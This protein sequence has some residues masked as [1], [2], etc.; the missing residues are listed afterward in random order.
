MENPHKPT[1][2]IHVTKYIIEQSLRM[3]CIVSQ[4]GGSQVR[5]VVSLSHLLPVRYEHKA[6]LL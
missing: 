6:I 5:R 1:A 2:A 4:F 3:S